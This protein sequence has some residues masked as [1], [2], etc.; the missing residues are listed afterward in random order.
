MSAGLRCVSSTI[1]RYVGAE[2]AAEDANEDSF[3]PFPRADSSEDLGIRRRSPIRVMRS[4]KDVAWS[5]KLVSESGSS[6]SRV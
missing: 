6:E 3:W 2:V 5:E 1:L 4:I